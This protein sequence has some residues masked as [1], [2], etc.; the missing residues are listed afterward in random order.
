MRDLGQTWSDMLTKFVGD[1]GGGL[2][3]IS[4]EL[5]TPK[6]FSGNLGENA[7]A[8][9][10]WTR[11][12]PVVSEPGLYQSA[13]DVKLSARETWN[14]ELTTDGSDDPIFR[15][16][17][18]PSKNRDILN[19]LPGMYWYYPVTRAK[20]GAAVL[21]QHGDQRMHNT[22]GRH[23]LMAMAA[24]RPGAVRVHRLRQH[25]SLALSAR[26]IFRRFLG[27]HD[28]PRRPQQSARRAVS[29][30]RVDGT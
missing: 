5:N 9:G 2:I 30:H 1:A 17:P 20:P 8:E 12:L 23:V 21:A 28:R 14:L 27:P 25:L 10:A 29:V 19:S 4:G 24:L 15:F 18:D 11:M 13:A 16:S 22:F 7:A 6:L 3:Y 26:R